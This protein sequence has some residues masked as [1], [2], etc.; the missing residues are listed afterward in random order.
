MMIKNYITHIRANISLYASHKTANILDGTYK[1]IYQGR[2]M[3]FDDLR[4]YIA[5]DDIKDIDWKSS[6][7]SGAI[8]IKKSH[9]EKKHNILLVLDTGPKMLA[10]TQ[11]GQSKAD[12]ALMTAGT[13]AYF[14]HKNGDYVG[15]IYSQ[16]THSLIL[17]PLKNTL[18]NLEHI[19]HTYAT[20][21]GRPPSRSLDMILDHISATMT[22][23]MILF[24]LT[25]LASLESVQDRTLKKI[26]LRH[27]TLIVTLIDGD[28]SGDTPYNMDHNHYIPPLFSQNPQLHALDHHIKSQIYAACVKKLIPY[29]ISTVTINTR[30]EIPRRLID[31]LERHRHAHIR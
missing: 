28:M 19:L 11:A 16:D 22:R 20:D 7:R 29:K 23:K 5:G 12:I 30:Q 3:D 9:I 15:A 4:E 2:N 18:Y 31:L 25:D 1:S 26:S 27:D 21:L 13:F 14:A 6:A 8:L 10:D 24:I 17:H